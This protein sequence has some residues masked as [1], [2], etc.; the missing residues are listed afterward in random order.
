[1]NYNNCA[2]VTKFFYLCL[3]CCL[4]LRKLPVM[5]NNLGFGWGS[6]SVNPFDQ[7]LNTGDSVEF[8]DATLSGDLT[9]E[10]SATGDETVTIRRLTGVKRSRLAFETAEVG[11]RHINFD[12]DNDEASL[13]VR[14]GTGTEIAEFD[15][16]GDF[17]VY[18]NINDAGSTVGQLLV[19]NGTTMEAL[20][21]GT[22]GQVLT[23]QDDLSVAW[24][25]P[26][27][28]NQPLNTG[29]DVEFKDIHALGTLDVDQATT[30]EAVEVNGNAV[31]QGT[32]SVGGNS[33]LAS[34]GVTGAA[35]VG[36]TLG[37]TGASTLASL[38]VTGSATVGTTLGVTGASTHTGGVLTGSINQF[39]P[40][41]L[42]IGEGSNTSWVR[43]GRN[44]GTTTCFSNML[45][46]R[47]GLDT[48]NADTLLLGYSNAVSI[49]SHKNHIFNQN[50]T[51]ASG[52]SIDTSASHALNLGTATCS[53]VSLGRTG[54][55]TTNSG[56]LTSTQAFTASS[57]SALTGQ[58]TMG[59]G[60]TSYTLPTARG[61]ANQCLIDN[62]SGVVSFGTLAIGAK[63]I[64]NFGGN[65]TANPFMIHMGLNSSLGAAGENDSTQAIIL[66]DGAIPR[67]SV[68]HSGDATSSIGIYKN[69]SLVETV[70][71]GGTG[72]II[73]TAGTTTVSTGDFISIKQEGGTN[74]GMSKLALIIT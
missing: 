35:T 37:V 20:A 3:L 36:T 13:I 2:Y 29:D 25:S 55:T 67:L 7:S 32:L 70:V 28:F 45:E 71:T 52:K 68:Q 27:I 72:G 62:G 26:V 30:L 61:S 73:P 12:L 22:D 39:E 8:K 10:D 21:P 41:A 40:G 43:I 59:S 57:T 38:S 53:A 9:L 6:A 5:T 60:G 56:P 66:M 17:Y 64:Y 65:L 33:T 16:N 48:I 47:V 51:V 23:M 49:T 42:S 44:G 14:S 4:T 24:S 69:Y 31:L 11:G 63:G 15:H 1:M 18:N 34:L 46:T 54:V 74:M 19:G 50:I 58:V